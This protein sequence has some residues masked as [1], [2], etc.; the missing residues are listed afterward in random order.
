M[1]KRPTGFVFN[2]KWTK[3]DNEELLGRIGAGKDNRFKFLI[4]C[5]ASP[6][7][8]RGTGRTN[9]PI[10]ADRLG[11]IHDSIANLSPESDMVK[12]SIDDLLHTYRFEYDP[13][14]SVILTGYPTEDGEEDI[15]SPIKIEIVE[16][17]K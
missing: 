12:T 2:K 17:S 3:E 16:V 14:G 10:E 1:T 15:E 7:G 5:F 9:F 11:D 13:E 8:N 6:E 4:G